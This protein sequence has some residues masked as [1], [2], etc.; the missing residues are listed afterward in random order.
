MR[1]ELMAIGMAI[2]LVMTFMPTSVAQAELPDPGTTPDSW[3]YG[4]DRA[5]ES[6]QKAIT[7]APEA[8]A[9]LALQLA[10]ERLVE[11][12][13]MAERGKPDLANEM[14]EDYEEE[15]NQAMEHGEKIAELAKR[16]EVQ[17]L[18]ARATS[19]HIDVLEGVLEKVPEQARPAI[20]RAINASKG[21][22]EISL[23]SLGEIK[24]EEA[25]KLRFEFAEKRLLK[26]RERAE[27]GDIEI[28]EDLIEEYEEEVHKYLE[29]TNKAREAGKDVMELVELVARATSIHIDVLEG[30][31]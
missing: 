4:L 11:A 8:R 3:L 12:R 23:D 27:E 17:E 10:Q 26:A 28:A 25:A 14:A 31:L 6:L 30:V 21:G 13:E 29:M 15:L 20:Q 16:G 9:K 18:V 19:I 1:K 7:R 24:P 22:R 2:M 5:F